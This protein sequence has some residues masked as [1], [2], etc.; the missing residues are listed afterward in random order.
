M[1]ETEIA[2]STRKDVK[3]LALRDH[4]K[5]TEDLT[6]DVELLYLPY[7]ESKLLDRCLCVQESFCPKHFSIKL[8]NLPDILLSTLNQTDVCGKGKARTT[9]GLHFCDLG[10]AHAQHFR[11]LVAHNQSVNF[12]IGCL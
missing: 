8:L 11:A 7:C 1:E 12:G 5:N 4:S 3:C 2:T 10:G 6:V 9:I